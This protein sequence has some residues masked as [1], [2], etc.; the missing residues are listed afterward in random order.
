MP[1]VAPNGTQYQLCQLDTNIISEIAKN[2]NGE[3]KKFLNKFLAE[4]WAVCIAPA[5]FIEIHR[6]EHVYKQ[7][8]DKFSIIP[9]FVLKSFDQIFE[10]E[11]D[12]YD[13]QKEISPI[14]VS[15]SFGSKNE[16]L[17]LNNLVPAAF[18]NPAVLETENHWRKNEN[19]T[20]RSWIAQKDN[21]EPTSVSPNSHDAERYVSEAKWQTIISLDLD[22]D[23]GS[24]FIK[25][26]VRAGEEIDPDRFPSVLV[27][28]YS[29]YYRLYDPDWKPEPQEITDVY[30]LGS[31]PILMLL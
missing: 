21:F 19:E 20:L 1:W 8:L 17:H 22:L 14:L 24:D 18:S 11:K 25:S 7:F 26:K 5:S 3:L 10:D 12:V 4:S 2:K 9:F 16:E 29:Q 23:I 27:I 31:V 6:N 28:L 13:T 15:I 30:M